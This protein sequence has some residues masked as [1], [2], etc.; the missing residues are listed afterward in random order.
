MTCSSF[1]RN[2]VCVMFLLAI[3]VL[4]AGS[5]SVSADDAI[6]LTI[7][8]TSDI[9]AQLL[10]HDCA[11]GT[12][13]GG[14]ARIKAYKESLE[15]QGRRVVILSSGD[16]FQGTLF[17]R[18]FRGMPDIDFMNRTG[19]TAMTVGNHEF[20]AGQDGMAEAFA[21]AKFPILSANL[22]FTHPKLSQLVKPSI[23]IPVDTPQGT[24]KIGLIGLT[25][26]SLF[27]EC[28]LSVLSGVQ[29]KNAREAAQKEIFRLKLDGA[30]LIFLVTHLGWNHDVELL[31]ALPDVAGVLG[32]HTH[33]FVDP[34]LVR[35]GLQGPQFISQP[36]E[37]GQVVSRIDIEFSRDKGRSGLRITGAGLIPMASSLPLAP[38]IQTLAEKLWKQVEEKVTAR[39]GTTTVKLDGEKPNVRSRET[40]LGDVV[41]DCMQAAVPSD[42]ALINGGGIR[43]SINGPA[44][45][46]ADC[47]NVLP[48]DNNLYK[49]SLSGS[50]L[51]KVFKQVQKELSTTPQFGG[52]L[53]VSK[54]LRVVYHS[55]GADLK[56]NGLDIADDATYQVVT[57]SFLALGGNGLTA[58]TEATASEAT[59]ILDVDALMKYVQQTGTLSQL[60]E[61]R[62]IINT[63][64]ARWKMPT[65]LIRVPRPHR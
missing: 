54:G 13:L 53:Q 42:L 43:N 55:Q 12:S 21:Q 33:L 7:L 37:G 10:P 58:F 50:S 19:Y 5:A 44:I 15:A 59:A 38:D 18:F 23:I 30:D 14:Y 60:V 1:L 57:N 56:L 40:N 52:F 6:P 51:K 47:L 46:I 20:D 61:G 2:S 17:F 29:V 39:L 16:V 24:L 34:P 8:H 22:S 27:Q 36:G 11:S 64:L 9:H 25:T 32:G 28:A 62:I 41:A 31:E 45:T 4:W 35:E 48:F 49:L 65:R 26:E 63:A 3:A